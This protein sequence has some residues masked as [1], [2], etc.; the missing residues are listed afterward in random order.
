MNVINRGYQPEEFQKLMGR[1]GAVL[2]RPK[3]E[4]PE[5]QPSGQ[6]QEQDS[7][8]QSQEAN[9][10]IDQS[11]PVM[12]QEALETKAAGLTL[13]DGREKFNSLSREDQQRINDKIGLENISS[14]LVVM[15]RM[16]EELEGGRTVQQW[17]DGLPGTTDHERK[18][19][20]DRWQ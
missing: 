11:S 16:R 6:P 8:T 7:Q 3:P 4:Q 15:S 1:G 13:D 14:A 17:L 9:R 5:K 20:G 18:L 10:Q 2:Y 12:D 19:G